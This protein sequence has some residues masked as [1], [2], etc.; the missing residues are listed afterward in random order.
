MQDN[1]LAK[2]LVRQGVE[3]SLIPMYTPIR[4]DEDDATN[5]PVFFGG[6]NV[7][8][9]YKYPL[10]RRIPR[11]FTRWLDSPW[12]LRLATKFGVS[13][14]AHELGG[15]TVAMLEGESGPHRQLVNEFV[16]YIE[17]HVK[18]DVIC[19]S[20]TLLVGSLR[21]LKR[22]IAKPVFCMLQG[23]D[24]FLD[25]L[26]E[27]H[28]E[29]V[30]RVLTERVR[31]FDGF[32]THSSFYSEYMAEYLKLDKKDCHAIP[33]GIDLQHHDGEP[34]Q[35]RE[36]FTVGYFARIAPEKGLLELAQAFQLLL[37]KHPHA[38]LKAGGHLNVHNRGYLDDVK[39]V[40]RENPGSFEYIGSPASHAQKVDF[41]KSVDVLSVPTKFQEPKG[42]YVLE[43]LANGVPVVLPNRGAFPELIDST[44]GGVIVESTSPE[45]LA[46][47]L[48]RVLEDADFRASLAEA[49]HAGVRATHTADQTAA[50]FV[51][52]LRDALH[53]SDNI[54][55]PAG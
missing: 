6:V 33:L 15:L 54:P 2:A 50:A 12:V 21:E 18:P 55:T 20:N 27:P 22:R 49:G 34:R 26:Q 23:D 53:A 5:T 31:D 14:D 41:Y 40:F 43:A 36:P 48:E 46:A 9:D 32:I 13:N 10:W 25:E 29:A 42:L 8:L 38:K 51:N 52:V 35:A 44:N 30:M 1:T 47:G 24:V 37:Q 4:V 11:L 45:H 16:D 19:F 7:Y 3:V 17:Q 39:A 28:R